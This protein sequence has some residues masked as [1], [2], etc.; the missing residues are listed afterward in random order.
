MIA[1]L[2]LAAGKGRRFGGDKL[3][4]DLDGKPVIRWSVEAFEHPLVDEIVVVVPPSHEGIARALTG[5]RVRLV[6]NPAPDRGMGSSIACGVTALGAGT[7]AVLIALADEPRVL[8]E[9]IERALS[10][11]AARDARIIAPT[12]RGVP[13]HPVLFDRSVFDEL[14]GLAGDRGARS[15]VDR[16]AS[17]VVVID[18]DEPPPIDVDTPADL[19]RLRER[20]APPVTLLDELM[21]EYDVR[22]SYGV[23]VAA[24]Q[25]TVYRAV[26]ETN[27]ANSSVARVLMGIRSLGRGGA[28]SFRFGR[29]P[30]HG[31]FF[32]LADDPPREAVAGVIGRFWSPRGNV[33]EGD[34]DA[35]LAP[36]PHGMAKGAFNFRVIKSGGGSR[37]TTET[38]VLCA[39]DDSRRRF[40]LYWLLVG[41]F[42]G[43]IRHEALRLIRRQT[44]LMSS[45][46]SQFP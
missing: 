21:P 4:Q 6:V 18:Y 22:A 5:K 36:L 15:I 40:R 7:Q 38:R 37:L 41:P 45:T 16:D 26:L 39:D 34:R 13:G 8:S 10:R 3:T 35:F 19:A 32:S 11:H 2:L 17:R 28:R 25:A 14:C 30:R 24:S 1:A 31:T 44:Q 27:L 46:Q 43:I 42:S 29:L 20:T 33:M 23:D 12:F 9:V